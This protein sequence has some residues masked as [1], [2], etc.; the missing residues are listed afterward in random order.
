MEITASISKKTNV[1]SILIS[2]IPIVQYFYFVNKYAINIPFL[3]DYTF[4]DFLPQLFS[5][6]TFGEKVELFFNQHNE[7]R[8]LLNRIVALAI[9][10]VKGDL[11]YRLMII[12]GNIF[13][14][15]ILAIF[16]K[17][18]LQLKLKS[19]Y[20]LPVPFLIFQLQL[21][22]NTFWGMASVQNFGVIFFI[23]CAIDC[24]NSQKRSRFYLTIV[25][26]FLATY[27]SGNGIISIFVCG[28]LLI[29]QK[30]AKDFLI[31]SLF[32][33]VFIGAY[34]FHYHSPKYIHYFEG[35]GFFEIIQGFFL[36]IGS[37]FDLLNNMSSRIVLIS[38]VGAVFFGFSMFILLS[39][40]KNS[41]LLKKGSTFKQIDLLLIGCLIF[42]IGTALIVIITRVSFGKHSLF[43]SRYK[44]YSVLLIVVLYFCLLLKADRYLLKK[45]IFPIIFLSIAYNLWSNYRN[46]YTV[47]HLQK[48]RICSLANN[49]IVPGDKLDNLNGEIYHKPNLW[50]NTQLEYLQKPIIEA[51]K[52]Q[53]SFYKT[54]YSEMLTFESSDFLPIIKDENAVYLILQSAKRVYLYPVGSH[55]S[56]MK[57]FLTTGNLWAKGFIGSLEYQYID[58]EKYH[59]G[60]LIQEGNIGKTYNLNDSLTI[61]HR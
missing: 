51:P 47:V 11:D 57:K 12:I 9:Y 21:W 4:F 2:I 22:E 46:Y 60:L 30:R 41:P 6:T 58:T 17:Y 24:I 27:T 14:L 32:S 7:H 39:F 59:L 54:P 23:L 20:F 10:Q 44:I 34:F 52:W 36:F 15:G 18:F 35:V 38:I 33:L 5:S 37:G 56:S 43:V 16:V 19:F 1:I 3:D 48:Q 50:L 42:V 53:Q 40:L 26:V 49:L 29:L 8:I 61:S 28:I 45:A 25:F 31:F 55:T 13:L